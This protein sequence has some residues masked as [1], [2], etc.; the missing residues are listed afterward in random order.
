VLEHRVRDVARGAD[1]LTG[2]VEAFAKQRREALEQLD[3]FGLFTRELEQRADFRVVAVDLAARVVEQERQD[4]L[5]DQPEERKVAV[6]PDLI[7]QEA[8]GRPERA[9][10][11]GGRQTI[12]QKGGREVER[13]AFPQHVFQTPGEAVRNLEDFTV[14]VRCVHA[15]NLDPGRVQA[16]GHERLKIATRGVAGK[17]GG[18]DGA[19]GVTHDSLAL[20]GL[21]EHGG[22][23]AKH[24]LDVRA[25]GELTLLRDGAPIPLPPSKKA[26]ALLGY[27]VLTRRA[28]RRERLANLFWD[29]ADDARGALR[30]TLS[31]VRAAVGAEDDPRIVADR[32]EVRFELANTTVDRFLV[33]ERMTAGADAVSVAELESA[34]ALFRGELLEGCD[35]PDFFEFTAW[36]SAEREEARRTR[37]KLLAALSE[38]LPDPERALP[39]ARDW[40]RIDPLDETAGTRLMRLLLA[41]G[42]RAEA[43]EHCEAVARLLASVGAPKGLLAT[44]RAELA[45][46]RVGGVEPPPESAPLTRRA[47]ERSVA[48]DVRF[49]GREHELSRLLRARRDSLRLGRPAIVVVSG[50]PGMGKSRLLAEAA[51][52]L[53]QDGVSVLSTSAFEADRSLPFL[54]WRALLRSAAAGA[55]DADLTRDLSPIM[56]ARAD[57]SDGPSSRDRLFLA[58]TRVLEATPVAMFD[59]AQWLDD[60]SATLLHHAL[61][62]LSQR[63][64]VCVLAVRSGEIAD[65]PAL[66]SVL[67]GVRRDGWLVELEVG[68]LAEE[69]VLELARGAGSTLEPARVVRDSEGSP[70]IAL[71]LSRWEPEPGSKIPHSLSAVVADRLSRLPLPSVEVVQWAAALGGHIEADMLSRLSGLTADALL[72]CLGLLERHAFLRAAPGSDGKYVLCHELL[73]RAVYLGVSEPRRKL[74]HRR[75]AELLSE[76]GSDAAVARDVSRHAALAGDSELA[77]N[78]CLRAAERCLR[79]F[80]NDEARAFARRGLRHAAVLGDE[81]R[82]PLE[83]QLR[84][85]A[86]IARRPPDTENVVT[87]LLHLAERAIDLGCVDDARAAYRVIQVL[88]WEVGRFEEAEQL[89]ASLEGIGRSGNAAE[90]ARAMAEAGQCLALLER[91]IPKA[92]QLLREASALAAKDSLEFHGVNSGLGLLRRYRGELSEARELF[93]VARGLARLDGDRL[94]EFEILTQLV[95]V[96]HQDGDLARAE[97]EARELLRLGERLPEGTE[98]AFSRAVAAVVRYARGDTSSLVELEEALRELRLSDA[99]HRVATIQLHAAEADLARGDRELALVRAR[100]AEALAE[101]LDRTN[102]VVVARALSVRASVPPNGESGAANDALEFLRSLPSHQLSAR[103]KRAI[104]LALESANVQD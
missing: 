6:T 100:E 8:L 46:T 38:R 91:D 63:P 41:A 25:L 5:L 71:E 77:A 13:L 61:R 68:P 51:A 72:G 59:D 70:L 37:V 95:E 97:R 27:L 74:M 33:A 40:V 42:R 47:L 76:R 3:V 14:G 44:L 7:E 22:A 18:F 88:R 24:T 99:T 15:Q 98:H 57:E 65:N 50:D 81:R 12:G 36:L 93:T 54:P 52:R 34:A 10:L 58:V 67:R 4:E 23:R 79:Q 26:R 29:V 96:A 35:L 83:I 20:D 30:W 92:E 9:K 1:H 19:R 45:R 78:A 16:R 103:A 2:R 90:R 21:T 73:G 94:A 84:R 17:S 56:A 80:A 102:D 62:T 49:V 60:A 28:H 75:I 55:F 69:E 39:Y 48:A 101:S 82:V 86:V 87:T 85:A 104:A 53:R 43:E 64:F 32:D 66:V 89:S 11:G 31:R